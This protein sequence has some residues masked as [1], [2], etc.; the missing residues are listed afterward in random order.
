MKGMIYMMISSICYCLQAFIL[1][2]LFNN[3]NVLA[4]EVTYWQSMIII[5]FEY[6]MIRSLKKDHFKIPEN[7]RNTFILRNITGFVGTTSYFV[8]IQYTDLSKAAVLYWTNP[9]FT[10]VI[11]YIWLKESLTLIDWG[12]IFTSFAGIII[13][14][15]P[16]SLEE[17]AKKFTTIQSRDDLIGSIAAITG[18]VFFAISLMQMRK[19]GK[20]VHFLLP[21]FYQALT[22]AFLGSM[23]MMV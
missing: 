11:A 10:A 2:L 16:W 19:M 14:E 8:A 1:K 7:M 5:V 12:A 3:S 15:N 4:Y 6:S 22:N 13:I 18:A 23:L 21:P 20:K 9:M 17:M